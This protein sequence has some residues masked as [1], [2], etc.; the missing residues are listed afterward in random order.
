[1]RLTEVI[2]MGVSGLVLAMELAVRKCQVNL[3]G[4]GHVGNRSFSF[5]AW[6][7]AGADQALKDTPA[8]CK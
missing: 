1:M 8:R 4:E 5:P 3:S 6:E 7:G 2:H